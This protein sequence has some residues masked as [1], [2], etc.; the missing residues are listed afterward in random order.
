M[1]IPGSVENNTAFMD[2]IITL[3]AQITSLEFATIAAEHFSDLL[4]DKFGPLALNEP[5]PPKLRA[6]VGEYHTANRRVLE[7]LIEH[8][9]FDLAYEEVNDGPDEAEA[10]WRVRSLV[11]TDRKDG[12]QAITVE[13][14]QVKKGNGT[15]ENISYILSQHYIG[16]FYCMI[17]RGHIS[18]V[19]LKSVFGEIGSPLDVAIAGRQKVYDWHKRLP[20]ED[21]RF[22]KNRGHGEFL[23]KLKVLREAISQ[24]LQQLN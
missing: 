15:S 23:D 7:R 3:E 6:L 13:H 11:Y 4:A 16:L 12:D 22:K 19:D 21:D 17:D 24:E 18:G 10:E 2:A 8:G 9:G 14:K 20:V 5:L 1:T